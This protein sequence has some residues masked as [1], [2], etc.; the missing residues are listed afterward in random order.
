MYVL[1]I[2]LEIWVIVAYILNFLI[3]CGFIL[4]RFKSYIIKCPSCGRKTQIYKSEHY[5]KAIRSHICKKCESYFI[6]CK[7]GKV[8]KEDTYFPSKNTSFIN[9]CK[10]CLHEHIG[11]VL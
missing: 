8:L 6:F 2:H 9:V 5:P 10:E 3:V 7:H 11:N 4:A 1:N